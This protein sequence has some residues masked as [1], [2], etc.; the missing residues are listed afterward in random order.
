MGDLIIAAAGDFSG[1]VMADDPPKVA[2]LS[3]G[4]DPR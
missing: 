2:V 4:I 3:D 1:V